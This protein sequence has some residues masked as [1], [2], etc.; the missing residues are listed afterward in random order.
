M[1]YD[2]SYR[3]VC[4]HDQSSK[5]SLSRMLVDAWDASAT[6]FAFTGDRASLLS[7]CV[8]AAVTEE[9]SV[10]GQTHASNAAAASAVTRLTAVHAIFAANLH[11]CIRHRVCVWVGVCMVRAG[12]S[13]G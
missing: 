6:R 11:S 12:C 7:S 3:F 4:K 1:T 8:S 2:M 13:E 10:G 9:V 5:M